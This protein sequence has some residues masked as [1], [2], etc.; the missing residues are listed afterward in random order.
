MLQ[1]GRL[2]AFGLALMLSLV[3]HKKPSP[4]QDTATAPH[5]PGVG[6]AGRDGSAISPIP[7]QT[8]ILMILMNPAV[9]DELKLNQDQK[10]QI[11]DLVRD[12]SKKS[13]DIM[14]AAL[15]GAVAG[16]GG[17]MQAFLS[18]G[19][20]V[21]Q[22]NERIASKVLQP[23]Q[24]TRVDQIILRVEGPLA[25]TRP[26]IASRL[27]LSPAQKQ[28]VQRTMLQMMQQQRMMF[29]AANQAGANGFADPLQQ[30]AAMRKETTRLR[31][32]AAAQLARILTTKQ[33]EGF[34][35][36]L[37]E[38]FDVR[39]DRSR[40]R[41]IRPIRTRQCLDRARQS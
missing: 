2:T 11:F 21:R 26:D 14:Q 36:M 39:Q 4:A 34:N 24:K 31:D 23:E 20:Q 28:N 32:A 38:P 16:G 37:G 41:P 10:T 13:R 27:E 40:A 17:G 22:E 8:N 18:A 9:Q 33:K 6:L 3:A 7:G 29:M 30:A 15:K 12:G 5:G 35:K 1:R 25:V 19:A